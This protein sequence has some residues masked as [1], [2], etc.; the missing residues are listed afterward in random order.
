MCAG[1]RHRNMQS[2]FQSA[3]KLSR[4]P[5]S[6]T[7]CSFPRSACPQAR[8]QRSHLILGEVLWT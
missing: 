2:A 1:F 5:T 7:V 4:F 6:R 3:V 8:E